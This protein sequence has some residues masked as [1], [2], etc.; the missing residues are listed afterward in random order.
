MQEENPPAEP[1]A[2]SGEPPTR[3]V[4]L[5]LGLYR[6]GPSW[7][8][9][10]GP[11]V[12][13]DQ[14]GHLAN[15]QR[16]TQQGVLLLSGPLQESDPYRGVIVLDCS[17]TEEARKRMAEDPHLKSGRLELELFPWLVDE[18]ALERPLRFTPTSDRQ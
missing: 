17:S 9:D 12:R 5:I 6:K 1:E 3:M 8:T 11:E 16:L 7:R 18:R 4:Q 10:A 14:R 2:V 13:Q 15:F